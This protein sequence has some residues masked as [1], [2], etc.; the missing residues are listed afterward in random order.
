M[1]FATL[2]GLLVLSNNNEKAICNAV[3]EIFWLF[4]MAR[5][6]GRRFG[7]ESFV[8]EFLLDDAD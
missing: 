2:G 1:P 8:R 3:S 7:F 6:V 4:W 5:E